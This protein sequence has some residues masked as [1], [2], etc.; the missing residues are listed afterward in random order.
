MLV[1]ATP[2]YTIFG[3]L[4]KAR[5]SIV[6]VKLIKNTA[7]KEQIYRIK[8]NLL[9]SSALKNKGYLIQHHQSQ[10][11]KSYDDQSLVNKDHLDNIF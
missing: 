4:L 10:Q 5:T 7:S 9:S 8:T 1:F 11:A 6:T 2:I 3:V